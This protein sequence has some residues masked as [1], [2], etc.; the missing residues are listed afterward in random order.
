M[1]KPKT[2]AQLINRSVPEA[3]LDIER[4]LRDITEAI[5]GL[6][7]QLKEINETLELT[8]TLEELEELF[9]RECDA[10]ENRIVTRIR[11]GT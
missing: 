5:G 7:I 8:A 10:M 11:N 2:R 1:P 6:G 4:Q 3:V 9:R